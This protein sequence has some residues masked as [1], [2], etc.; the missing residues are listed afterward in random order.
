M[1]KEVRRAELLTIELVPKSSWYSNVRSNLSKEEWDR[2]RKVVF[3]RAG[4]VCEVCGNVGTRWPVECHEVFEYD[5]ARRVQRLARLMALCPS[6]HE[7][8]HIGLAGVRG[9]RR[10]AL[11][12]LAR[13]NDWSLADAELYAEGCFELWHRRSCHEW[14]LD[15]DYLK[16]FGISTPEQA[17]RAVSK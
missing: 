16:Q 17:S 5:D 3:K 10:Q 15:L 12:H 7:V 9:R 11:S 4:N 6:C 1:R 14:T 8:K 2:I 13:V